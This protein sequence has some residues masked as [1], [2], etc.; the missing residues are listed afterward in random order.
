MFEKPCTVCYLFPIHTF[1]I[2]DQTSTV[3]VVLASYFVGLDMDFGKPLRKRKFQMKYEAF[4]SS[5]I[6]LGG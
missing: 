3:E 2:S 6:I 5:E 1:I 4:Y